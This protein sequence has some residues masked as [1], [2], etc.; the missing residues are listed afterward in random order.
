[1]SKNRFKRIAYASITEKTSI[2]VAGIIFS[3]TFI[4]RVKMAGKWQVKDSDGSAIDIPI[5]SNSNIV[6]VGIG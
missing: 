3:I 5:I 4:A 1:L 2:V 6:S